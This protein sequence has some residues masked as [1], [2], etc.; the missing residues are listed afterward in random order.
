[1]PTHLPQGRTAPANQSSPILFLLTILAVLLLA[2]L[3]SAAFMSR[4]GLYFDPDGSIQRGAW[5]DGWVQV[6]FPP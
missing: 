2:I 5:K 6:A 4:L 3:L 1:M